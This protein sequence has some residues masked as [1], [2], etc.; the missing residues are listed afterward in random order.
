MNKNKYTK[1]NNEV[2]FVYNLL[3]RLKCGELKTFNERLRSQKVQ[4]IAQLFG[5]V[6]F[7][8]YN[9]YIHGPYSPDLAKDLFLI[10]KIKNNYIIKEFLPEKLEDKFEKLKEFIKNLNN[11]KLELIST[12][13][14]LLYQAKLPKKEALIKLKELKN[15]SKK[16]IKLTK[17]QLK[18]LCKH[19][20][21]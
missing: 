3:K 21:Q 17:N 4:Y 7:Y 18:L 8:T 12:Y 5:V 19:I 11:R 16:E 13:H 1:S 2:T 15:P 6:P 14:W 10:S 20:N 9:L